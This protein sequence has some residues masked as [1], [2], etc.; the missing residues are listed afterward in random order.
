L[1]SLKG[2]HRYS[3]DRI[4]ADIEVYIST[5]EQDEKRI[6]GYAAADSTEIDQN[7]F[8]VTQEHVEGYWKRLD[9]EKDYFT[10]TDLGFIRLNTATNDGQMLAVAYRDTSGRKY[11]DI[12]FIFSQDKADTIHLKLIKPKLS[13][14]KIKPGISCFATFIHWVVGYRKRRIRAKIFY[15]PPQGDDQE[16]YTKDG[17][18]SSWLTLL[19]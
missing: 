4:I 17:V 14:R 6:W 13:V 10:A 19:A 3:P 15:H 1:D 5:N 2:I 11:G 18:V 16:T 12:P 7:E 8:T 9:K